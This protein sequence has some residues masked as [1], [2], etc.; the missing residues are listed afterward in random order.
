MISEEMLQ[1]SAARSCE[2]Y[3]A[4][5]E[6]GYDSEDAHQFSDEFEKK[7]KKLKHKADHPV[8]YSVMRYVAS[9][10]LVILIAGSA[11]LTVDV[12]AREALFGWVKGIYKT[13]FV[14]RYRD[15]SEEHTSTTDYRPTWLPSSY[16]EFS[17]YETN[18]TITVVFTDA[19]GSGL[20]MHYIHNPRSADWLVDIEHSEIKSTTVSGKP[21]ELLIATDSDTANAIMW[22]AEDNT[23]F[24][25]SG[26]LSEEE[27]KRIAESIRPIEK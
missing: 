2:I 11:W 24:Y 13:Y 12:E 14:Y 16:S 20:V 6:A 1:I 25:L 5:L 4:Q 8:F 22:I 15:Y 26:F 27:L 21:A 18:S 3:A 17:S 10:A 9:V 7:I 23:A 19:D